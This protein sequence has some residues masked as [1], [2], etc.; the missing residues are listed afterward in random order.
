MIPII[1][2]AACMSEQFKTTVDVHTN[3]VINL[4]IQTRGNNVAL[5][6]RARKK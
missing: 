5:F 1:L 6:Q 4:H 2:V 3:Y